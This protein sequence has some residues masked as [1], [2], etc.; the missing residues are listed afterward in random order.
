[1]ETARLVLDSQKQAS[2]EQTISE[3]S[4]KIGAAINLEN[5]LETTL[6]EMGRVLPGADIS[7]QVENE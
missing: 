4:S 7:I 5:I 1:M 3:I 6:R 2:K